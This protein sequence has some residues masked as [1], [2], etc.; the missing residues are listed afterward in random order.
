MYVHSI[1][2]LLEKSQGILSS[3]DYGSAVKRQLHVSLLVIINIC[4]GRKATITALGGQI[5]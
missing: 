2:P 1:D 4:R 3:V 5:Q